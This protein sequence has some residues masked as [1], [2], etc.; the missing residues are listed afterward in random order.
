MNAASH[1][2]R[3]RLL[4]GWSANL[5]QLVLGVTQQLALIPII[6]HYCSSG[7][8]A[9]WLALY[10]AG[11]LVLLADFGLQSRAINLFLSF[12]S[13]TDNERRTAEYFGAM[14]QLYLWLAGA[15]VGSIF[16]AAL[17]FS[18]ASVLGF[19]GFADFDVSFVLITIGIALV[20]PSNLASGLYRARG[21]YGRAVWI[22]CFAMLASQI[23]QVTAIMLTGRLWVIVVA[24]VLPQIL[25]AA[26]LAFFDTWR[27]FPFLNA[28]RPFSRPSAGWCVGQF[29]KAIPFAVAGST[30]IALQNLPVL[31][32]SALVV[33]RVA[34]A[35]WGLTRVVAGLVR[36]LCQQVSLPLAA[37]L[38]LDRAIADR[39]ALQRLYARGSALV[40]LLAGL[41]V[42][43]LLAFWQDF[44]ELWTHGSIRYDPILTLLL[45]IGAEVGAPAVLALGYGYYSNRGKL[46]LHTKVL[47][48]AVFL[49]LAVVLTPRMGPLGTALAVVAA[50]LLVQ[51]GLL[52]GIIIWE[53]LERPARHVTFLA[54]LMVVITMGGW[55]FG[56]AI[57][58]VIPVTGAARFV[59]ECAL[60]V[61]GLVLLASNLLSRWLRAQLI[62]LIP[63]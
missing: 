55:T 26:Y 39:K 38:G 37:E 58:S 17:R 11:S 57:R 16:V 4:G 25:A 62:D 61:G 46:L 30:E 22:Q 6:L 13:C 18:P 40:T 59:V 32:I 52:G 12:K 54:I 56:W 41:V 35:Q 8:L 47:Q 1:S 51:L 24:F 28:A 19:Q 7:M 29:R 45:L 31:L 60:W 15:L 43:G 33:D 50:D 48:F 21:L 63:T 36:A 44:F 34:V 10:A 3:Q 2:R 42:S 53:T 49:A 27:M 23:A 14:L 9:A 5:F 20:I